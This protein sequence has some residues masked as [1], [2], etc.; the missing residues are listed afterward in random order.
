[1]DTRILTRLKF[2]YRQPSKVDVGLPLTGLTAG[3]A[4]DTNL[5]HARHLDD[6]SRAGC[7]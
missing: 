2:R 6:W 3:L 4:S 5:G 1:M 7:E